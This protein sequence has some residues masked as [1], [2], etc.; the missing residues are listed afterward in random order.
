MHPLLENVRPLLVSPPV[1][2]NGKWFFRTVPMAEEREDPLDRL[3]TLFKTFPRLYEMVISLL[4]PVLPNRRPLH[5]FLASTSGV[6]LNIGSGNQR[7]APHIL[8]VD[9]FAYEHVDIV[10]DIHHL[11]FRDGTV[12]GV[13][14]SAVLEHVADPEAVVQEIH[15][16][17]KPGGHV[18]CLIP[19]MQ[20]FHASPHDYQ[21]YTLPGIRHLHRA[22][23]EL[24]SGVAGGPVSG[25]LWMFQEWLATLFSFGCIP[26]RNI[27]Y[28]LIMSITWPLKYLDHPYRGLATATN[29]ASSFY[30]HAI[31]PIPPR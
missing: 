8:N 21:R 14:S 17:L 18:Y 23:T 7:I 9:L 29:I 4:S 24:E 19:F 12:D 26:L 13:M 28:L 30:I 16:V 27:L 10:A 25:F 31:R 2:I 6:V 5:R 15:R 20:P 22:F 3:K 1:E 11:P